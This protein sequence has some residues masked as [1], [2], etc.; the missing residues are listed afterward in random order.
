MVSFKFFVFLFLIPIVFSSLCINVDFYPVTVNKDNSF[1]IGPKKESCYKYTLTS[2]KGKKL[3][4]VFPKTISS[5]S[6]VLLYK[7]KSDIQIMSGEYRNYLERFLINENGFKEIDLSNYSQEIFFVI[8][9]GKYNLD[10]KNYFILYD[11]EIPIALTEGKPLT[12]K[13]FVKN[14]EYKFSFESKKNLTFVYSTKVKNKKYISI[15]YDNKIILPKS[16]DQTDHLFNLKNENATISKQLYITVEDIEEGNEDQEFSV[17]VYEKNINQ[18]FGVTRG[19]VLTTNYLSLNYGD[20]NQIFFFYYK[21]E[22]NNNKINSINIK[23]NSLV[24]KENYINIQTGSYHSMKDIPDNEKDIYFRFNENKFPIK[25]NNNSNDYTKIF[26]QDSD[27][28][29]TYRY[30]YFKIEILKTEKYFSPQDFTIIIGHGVEEKYYKTIDYN[31]VQVI[32]I[33]LQPNIPYYFKINIDEK[34]KYL[35]T[36]PKPDTTV[37]TKGELIYTDENNNIKY[38]ENTFTDLDEI[39]IL[40]GISEL[41][42]SVLNNKSSIEYYYLEKFVEKD[43]T[44]IENNRN[45]EPIEI[46]FDKE[47]CENKKKKY[48]LGIYNKK[49]YGNYNKSYVKYWT[50]KKGDFNVF[51]RNGISYEKNSIFPSSDKFLQKKE[52]TIMLKFH[53]DF[54][55]FTCKKPGILSLRSPYKIFNET[56]HMIIQNS[57]STLSISNKLEILQFTAPMKD[58]SNFYLYLG[59]FSKYGR[60]IKINP[61]Y[62]PLFKER[63]IEYDTPFLCSVDL[64]KYQSDQLAIKIQAEENTEIEVIEVIK[65]NFT[66]YSIISNYKKKK[67][68]TNNLVRYLPQTTEKITFKINGLKDVVIIYGFVPLFSNDVNYLPMA[69]QFSGN[70]IHRKLASKKESIIIKNPFLH[71]DEILY[72]KYLAFVCSIQK[73]EKYSF[74][75]QV[76]ADKEE[77][78]AKKDED[79][80]VKVSL[81]VVGVLIL[82]IVIGIVI[83]YFVKKKKSKKTED[84]DEFIK[85]EDNTNNNEDNNNYNNENNNN[86]NEEN[87]NEE[88]NNIDSQIENNNLIVN[89]NYNS[90][91]SEN[92]KNNNKKNNNNN[93]NKYIRKFDDEEDEDDRRLYKSFSED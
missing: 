66:T 52:Y 42:V 26:Y 32:S 12:I 82:I 14:N 47:E 4:L 88:E 24:Y 25:Y 31:K 87:L 68:T 11:T 67:I 15:T 72:K 2:T 7:S 44:I 89:S 80:A 57:I 10:Y 91:S 36:S 93:K 5:T 18:F 59:I 92:N 75:A 40:S 41:T 90:I 69:Y 63:T 16:I 23:L 1:E 49:I 38:N 56:T 17:I 43:M 37:Y 50:S 61:D 51:Y 3:I 33:V 86:N 76:I 34:E 83:Y 71:S 39:I 45:Y 29:F 8:R 28:S 20:E 65:Y 19:T 81:S 46:T 77:Q 6:E 30:I 22:A 53:L 55:T 74:E 79:F 48:L 60:R 35:F 70:N 78:K 62:A 64:H 9:D 73:Y 84:L 54:F 13:Y 21:L 58:P 27:T 85:Q